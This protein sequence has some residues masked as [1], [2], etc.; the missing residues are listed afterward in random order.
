MY[1][2]GRGTPRNYLR[3]VEWFSN[4]AEQ[5]DSLAQANLGFMHQNGFGV[6]QDGE[7]AVMSQGGDYQSIVSVPICKSCVIQPWVP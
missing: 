4:A 5:S 6:R 1:R 2:D 3:A 7:V